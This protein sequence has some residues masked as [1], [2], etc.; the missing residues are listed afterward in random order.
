[1]HENGMIERSSA[2]YRDGTTIK[3]RSPG[4]TL[5]AKCLIASLPAHYERDQ[6]WQAK[7]TT[8]ADRYTLQTPNQITINVNDAGYTI[9]T[10]VDLDLSAAGSWDAVA[11]DY[12]VAANRAGKDFYVYACQPDPTTD[13]EP[14]TICSANATYPSGYT[15]ANSRKVGGFHCLCVAAGTIAGHPLSDYA[16]G[17]ILSASIW[18]LNHRPISAPAGMIYNEDINLWVDIYLASGTGASTTSANG[19]VITDTRNWMDFVD[20]GHAVKK[21]LL[22]DEEFQ[23]IAAGSNEETNIA[24]SADPGTTGGHSDT[25]PRRMISNI[26][27]EDCCGGLYQWLRDQSWRADALPDTGDPAWAWY[28]L[29][30]AKGSLYKQGT[31]GDVKLRA[32]GGWNNAAFCGSRYRDASGSR[33]HTYSDVGARFGAKP[34]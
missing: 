14:V 17:D 33:W 21:R 29:P 9:S 3:P 1:M 19:A 13:T 24:G 22:S 6:K 25:T 32:G 27:G 15:A 30:G 26:G 12:R 11:P 4:D 5:A 10:Q 23:S 2:F 18:D 7:G 34:Q 28:D 31:H 20:D 8:G 16:Q